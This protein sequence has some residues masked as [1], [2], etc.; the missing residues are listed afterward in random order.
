MSCLPK[1]SPHK[2]ILKM[3]LLVIPKCLYCI[4]PIYTPPSPPNIPCT[5]MPYPNFLNNSIPPALIMLSISTILLHYII[6]SINNKNDHM[7]PYITIFKIKLYLK[8]LNFQWED[9]PLLTISY[10]KLTL[11]IPVISYPNYPPQ[12]N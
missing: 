11:L 12:T 6:T 7:L 5:V 4:V 8:V 9:L 2:C 3:Y 10:Q 1:Q